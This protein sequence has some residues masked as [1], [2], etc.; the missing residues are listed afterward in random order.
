MERERG[1]WRSRGNR[2]LKERDMFRK[3]G[4]KAAGGEG[5]KEETQRREKGNDSVEQKSGNQ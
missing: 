5:Q 4:Y 2:K 3:Y 1:R